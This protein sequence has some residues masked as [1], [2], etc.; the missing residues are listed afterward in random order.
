MPHVGYTDSIT[1]DEPGFHSN[2]SG[3]SFPNLSLK[4]SRKGLE[5]PTSGISIEERPTGHPSRSNGSGRC[6][7]TGKE[8]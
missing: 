4:P 6:R 1:N 3:K 5:G 8:Q 2:I 7:E